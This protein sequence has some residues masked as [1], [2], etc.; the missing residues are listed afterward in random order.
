MP[1]IS[2]R[3]QS[4]DNL[5]QGSLVITSDDK[6]VGRVH[7]VDGDAI[8]VGSPGVVDFWIE[9]EHVESEDDTQVRLKLSDDEL[10][11]LRDRD[12]THLTKVKLYGPGDSEQG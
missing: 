8:R 3:S 12:S 7:Q 1:K 9:A 6:E 4:A 5:D 2:K 10:N 11:V